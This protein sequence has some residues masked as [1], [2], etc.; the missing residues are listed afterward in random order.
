MSRSDEPY[1]TARCI[2]WS[3]ERFLL[4]VHHSYM[5][6]RR[7]R[8]GL[9]GGRIETGESAEAAARREVA[10]ELG[11]ELG[12]LF[13]CGDYAYK[14]TR[15]KVFGARF[16]GE[17]AAFDANEIERIGW[18]SLEDVAALARNGRLHAGFEYDAIHAFLRHLG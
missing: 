3:G 9:P 12:E 14:G 13:D 2:L 4:A 7:D 8:W 6:L 18:H 5:P 1:K 11:I 10:E 16:S 17:V 15:H